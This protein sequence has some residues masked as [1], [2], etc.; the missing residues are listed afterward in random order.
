MRYL[1]LSNN[2]LQQL[3]ESFGDLQ[4][5]EHLG[6][7]RCLVLRVSGLMNRCPKTGEG[8]LKSMPPPVKDPPSYLHL[9]KNALRSLPESFGK[10]ALLHLGRHHEPLF[11]KGTCI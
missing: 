10:L 2:Q 7:M 6:R 11:Y 1:E 4:G 9:E 5:L 8:A 3:P